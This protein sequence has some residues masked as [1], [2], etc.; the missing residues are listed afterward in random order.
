MHWVKKPGTSPE[1]MH[2]ITVRLSKAF[3]AMPDRRNFDSHI[4]RT[5]VA[6]EIVGPNFTELWI[7][8]DPDVENN[9]NRSAS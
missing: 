4:G 5:E 7:S 3:R 9:K 6:D 1:S 2:R 8:L